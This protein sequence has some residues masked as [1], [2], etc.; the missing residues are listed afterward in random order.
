MF[1]HAHRGGASERGDGR[2]LGKPAVTGQSWVVQ[3]LYDAADVR[4]NRWL[5]LP[6]AKEARGY[7]SLFGFIVVDCR[8]VI[9]LETGRAHWRVN[10]E[11]YN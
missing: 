7:G 11:S 5:R 6:P 8:A 2:W 1:S 4:S 10:P 3:H 9:P